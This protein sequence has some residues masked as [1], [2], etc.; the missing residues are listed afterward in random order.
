MEITLRKFLQDYRNKGLILVAGSE[1]IDCLVSRVTV[2]D[3]PDG[4]SWLRGGEFVLTSTFQFNNDSNRLCAFCEQLINFKASGFGLKMGRYL[5]KVPQFLI[6]LCDR[7][8]FPLVIIPYSLV[9]TDVISVFYELNYNLEREEKYSTLK[10]KLVG[11]IRVS[12]MQGLEWVGKKIYSFFDAPMLFLDQ[13][14]KQII[15]FGT[16]MEQENMQKAIPEF[17]KNGPDS[18]NRKLFDGKYYICCHCLLE[19]FGAKYVLFSSDSMNILGEL[20]DI[21]IDADVVKEEDKLTLDSE[22]DLISQALPILAT[23]GQITLKRFEDLEQRI[24]QTGG[25]YC[26]L[27]IGNCRT[28]HIVEELK[29][30]IR[31]L[32]FDIRTFAVYNLDQK[33][34]LVLLRFRKEQKHYRATMELR[35]IMSRISEYLSDVEITESLFVSNIYDSYKKIEQSYMEAKLTSQYSRYMWP[36][37]RLCYF[38]EI[39]PYY[40]M[41]NSDISPTYLDGLQKLESEAENSNFD[42]IQTLEAYLRFGNFKQAAQELFIHENTLRYRIKKIGEMIYEDFDDIATRQNYVVRMNLWKLSRGLHNQNGKIWD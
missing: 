15:C 37:R 24:R 3:A 19:R 40:L 41:M 10:S 12:S 20:R 14:W 29:D 1:G 22:D 33:M 27:Y 16:K 35:Q 42:C 8:N 39:F 23:G 5:T 21:L 38:E 32:E 34:A 30:T 17:M 26:V 6:D 2:L 7:N 36:S 4:P 31:G 13:S 18:R 25:Y 9:W 28:Q 11:Q